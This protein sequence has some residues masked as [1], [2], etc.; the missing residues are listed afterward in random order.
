MVAEVLYFFFRSIEI[1]FLI[2]SK[3]NGDKRNN[4]NQDVPFDPEGKMT[5]IMFW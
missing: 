4:L 1:T 2:L 3:L 5:D